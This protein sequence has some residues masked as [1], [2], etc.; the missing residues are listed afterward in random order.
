MEFKKIAIIPALNEIENKDILMLLN[1]PV[2][3]Y[4]IEAAIK[5]KKFDKIII[6][7]D[8]LVYKNIAEK[9]DIEVIGSTEKIINQDSIDYA[10][11]LQ[12]TSPFRDEKHIIESI[13]IFE[14]EYNNIDSL[15]SVT[16]KEVNGA[17]FI[18]KIGKN[19]EKNKVIEYLMNMEDSIEINSELNFRIAQTILILR[20][21]YELSLNLISDKI[22]Y[23]NI[24]SQV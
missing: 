12:T 8:S 22:E 9:Y 17:I 2:I 1:K 21:K 24:Y 5:S 20:K 7:T 11:F 19:I 3:A 16:N 14:K 23:D 13:E 18:E 4:T 10:V 15:V 6:K